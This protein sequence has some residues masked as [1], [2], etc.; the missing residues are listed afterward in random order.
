MPS[1]TLLQMVAEEGAIPD[2]LVFM[3]EPERQFPCSMVR[4]VFL[5]FVLYTVALTVYGIVVV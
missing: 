4:L 2:Q 3:E 1:Q 5:F